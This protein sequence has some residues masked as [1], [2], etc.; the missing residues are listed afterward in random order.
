[1]MKKSVALL[2]TL[3]M[4]VGT[5]ISVAAPKVH[6]RMATTVSPCVVFGR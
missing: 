3:V 5:D 1:M 4:F 2:A 6:L